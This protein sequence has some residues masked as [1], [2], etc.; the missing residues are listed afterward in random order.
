MKACVRGAGPASG[1]A[2]W[3]AVAVAVAVNWVVAALPAGVG[4]VAGVAHAEEGGQAAKGRKKPRKVPNMQES[5]YRRLSEIQTHIEEQN[6]QEAQTMLLQMLE[7]RRRYNNNERAS[8]HKLLAYVFFEL[9]DYANAIQQFEQVI[10]QVPDITEGVENDTLQTLAK[11]YFQEAVN[12]ESGSAKAV[13]LYQKALHTIEDWMTKVDEVGADAHQFIASVYFQMGNK[14]KAIEHMEKAVQLAQERNKPVKENWWHLLQNLYSESDRWDRVA[15]IGEVLVKDYPKRLNWMTLVGA[16]GQIDEPDKQL[17]AMEAAH[18]G[19]HLERESDFYIYAGLLLQ[20]E[21]PNRASK[22]LRASLDEK[23]VERN[24]KNLS[25]LGQA[26]HVAHE[27]EEAISVFEEAGELADDGEPFSRL[28]ALHL[29]RYENEKCR[30]AADRALEKGDLRR[31]LATKVTLATCLFNMKK[32]SDARDV[33]RAVLAE[34]RKSDD[35][36]SEQRVARDWLKY[37]ESERR[38]L[39]EI[40]KF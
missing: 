32:L 30:N 39:A 15:Q 2:F 3:V 5:T 20:N 7:S 35:A 28:A 1:S 23:Q 33:F 19:G 21:M 26:Y 13:E 12:A 10:A 4:E 25:L 40:A 6:Y 14:P 16:Y 18:A 27:V 36:R 24:L 31:P 38:R 9:E 17:W 37:I 34:A 8:M 22:Y 11:L 29:Q